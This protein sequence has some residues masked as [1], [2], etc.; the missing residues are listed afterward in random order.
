M[1]L[2]IRDYAEALY[3]LVSANPEKTKGLVSRFYQKLQ[4]DRKTNLL[5]LIVNELQ[6][7]E[8]EQQDRFRVEVVTARPLEQTVRRDMRHY[9]K[10]HFSKREV[11]IEETIDPDLIGGLKIKVGDRVV[12]HTIQGKLEQLVGRMES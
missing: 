4:T 8:D 10:Q 3:E 5:P 6:R 1:K 9:L 7:L 2:S 11:E 12:D